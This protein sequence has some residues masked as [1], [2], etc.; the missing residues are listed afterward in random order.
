MARSAFTSR[1]RVS[2]YRTAPSITIGPPAAESQDSRKRHA[3][4]KILIGSAIALSALALSALPG[5]AQNWPTRPVNFMLPLGP[6]SGADIGARL[7]AEKLAA[8]WGQPVVVENRPGGDG[9]VAINAFVSAQRRSRAAVRPGVLVHRASLSARQAA[10]RPARSRAGCARLG[11][12][13]FARA[14]RRNSTSNRCGDL[15]A[16]ARAKPGKLN[17]ATITGATDLVLAAFLKGEELEMAKMPYRDPVQA[18]NDVAEGRLQLYWAALAIVRGAMQAGR[19]KLLAITA[20]EPS[21]GRA[22]R[23][24]RDAGRLPGADLRRAGRL[25][26]PARHAARAP[27]THRRR[28]PR[29]AWPIR[30]SWSVCMPPARMSC[31]AR[32]PNSPPRSTGSAQTVAAIAK[33]LGIK[34]RPVTRASPLPAGCL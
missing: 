32:P 18:L 16:M 31:R 21:V 15:V 22:G 19:V 14:C 7:I 5:T 3:N 27:R 4:C 2:L 34:A 23:A 30:R 6:G 29:S 12:A 11:H 28:R 24:D 25:L 13:D 20:S 1:S 9:F 33:V 10:L 8:K 17:W 26:R